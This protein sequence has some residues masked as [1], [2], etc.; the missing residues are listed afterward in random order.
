LRKKVAFFAVQRSQLQLK[1]KIIRA[2]WR[3]KAINCLPSRIH[4]SVQMRILVIFPF[5]LLFF[6]AK[7]QDANKHRCSRAFCHHFS[8]KN[9]GMADASRSDSLDITQTTLHLDF[10][11]WSEQTLY[12]QADLD[13]Q[14]LVDDLTIIALDL[15]SFT[16][17]SVHING[18]SNDFDYTSPL[19]T[20]QLATALNTDDQVTVSVFYHG[21]PPTDESGWGGFY[22]QNTIAYNLG[23]GFDADPHSYG[24]AWHPCFDN[25][26]E[27]SPYTLHVLHA[28]EH[29]VYCGG[30]QTS[31]EVLSED[32]TLTTYVLEEHIPSYLASV[33]VGELSSLE[34]TYTTALGNTIPVE[35]ATPSS[36]LGDVAESFVNLNACTAGFEDNF[37]P[38]RWPR[39]GYVMV[40]FNAGA[41]EHATNIAYP[42]A[43]VQ[44]G[45][46][47][48]EDL[49]AHEL[50]HHWWGDLVTCS[51]QEDMWLNEGMASYCEALFFESFYGEESY[52]QKVRSNHKDVLLYAHQND[53]ERLPVS[54]I[55]HEHTYGD[56]V[57][58]KGASMAHNL[59]SYLGEAFFPLLTDFLE[60]NA[61]SD[62]SSEELRDY[63]DPLTNADITSFFD[64]WIFA[65]G[66][67]DIRLH[68]FTST[69][70]DNG[71]DVTVTLRQYLHYA[72]ELY[73]NVPVEVTF[74]N[75]LPGDETYTVSMNVS[76]LESSATFTGLPFDPA[77]VLV[78]RSEKLNQAA[79]TEERWIDTGTEVFDHS[80]F[81]ITVDAL[82]SDSI[83]FRIENH[84]TAP[85]LSGLEGYTIASDRFWRIYSGPTDGVAAEGRLRFY[86]NEGSANYFD[87]LFFEALDNAGLSEEDLVL[88]WRS[89]P[90]Q[91]WAVHPQ[92]ELNTQG[93]A[94]NYQG[95]IDFAY[96]G[97]GDYAWAVAQEGVQVT[98]SNASAIR[99][100]PNPASLQL[101]YDGPL[102]VPFTITDAQ[103][104]AVLEGTTAQQLNIEQLSPG[105]YHFRA[106]ARDAITFI[107]E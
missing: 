103:G 79:L 91:T 48:F 81:R 76:G 31:T 39:V 87:P 17:D 51:T 11:N 107:K 105:V 74:L 70:V 69:P 7:A 59:R 92:Y 62:I 55:G 68:D 30:L 13:M 67:T 49:M 27:R 19:L 102:N 18:Q 3:V 25:F 78:N 34:D 8:G 60:L 83:W 38:Y 42:Q 65:P 6:C 63:L 82:P 71:F 23:V 104:R 90:T 22:W 9:A 44:N 12:G 72:P 45:T 58:N 53:G 24:R 50:S 77:L 75:G 36:L 64:N 100:Y 56:H 54:G 97:Q 46:L 73:T 41:M 52:K 20:I 98:E 14:V 1:S 84:W 88:L 37:G 15:E 40:P 93:N 4:Y 66:L 85:E 43:A 96:L 5:L 106:K 86:G 101:F 47:S 32:S 94:N 28:P 99:L 33:A 89:E 26:V 80:E 35:L 10:I 61:Y 95:Y 21:S 29:S 57:Y 2:F 16:I